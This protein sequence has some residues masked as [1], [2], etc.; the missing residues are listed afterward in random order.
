MIF[1]S[2]NRIVIFNVIIIIFLSSFLGFLC[3]YINVEY[4]YD[5]IAQYMEQN[6]IEINPYNEKIKYIAFL[7]SIE[8]SISCMLIYVLMRKTLN[9]F[10]FSLIKKI[11]IFSALIISI[12]GNLIRQPIMDYIIG[13]PLNIVFQQ[14]ILIWL[15]WIIMSIVI[16]VGLEFF[17]LDKKYS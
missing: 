12:H 6:N 4:F 14:N 13:N 7:S 16:I 11:I 2:S 10:K 1:F 3:H 8:Y 15:T 9:A 5:Y 17:I